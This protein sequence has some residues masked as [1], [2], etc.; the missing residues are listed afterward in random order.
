MDAA[1]Q[2]GAFFDRPRGLSD[3]MT[4][5]CGEEEGWILGLP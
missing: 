5:D 3:S 1:G 4:N 2:L